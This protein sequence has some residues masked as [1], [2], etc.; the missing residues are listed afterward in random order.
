MNLF[1]RDKSIK[2]GFRFTLIWPLFVYKRHK[3]QLGSEDRLDV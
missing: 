2:S 1:W 3:P